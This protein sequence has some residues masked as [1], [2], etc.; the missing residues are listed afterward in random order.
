M[1]AGHYGM[2]KADLNAL[3]AQ[4]AEALGEEAVVVAPPGDGNPDTKPG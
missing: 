3:A 4:V 2:S 1:D